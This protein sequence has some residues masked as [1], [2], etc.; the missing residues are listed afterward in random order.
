MKQREFILF[1]ALVSAMAALAIDMLLPAF[2]DIRPDF[3]LDDNSTQLSLTI[4][5]FFVG[6][7]VG[8]LVY[9]PL[10]D[11]WG[12]KRVL[13]L[14]LVLYA[15]AAVVCTLANS[16]T[17]LL[18]GRF[19]WGVGSGGPRTLSQAIVRD[20]Y[21][22]TAMARIMTLIQAAFF[23]GPIIA[24]VLGKG[25]V[26]I[27]SWRWVTAF[28]VIT[29]AAVLLWSVRL[30]ETLPPER[31]RNLEPR[32]IIAGF[33]AVAS[34]RTTVAYGLS[35][36]FGFGAFYSFLASSELIFSSVFERESL[37]VWFFVLI[38]VLFS[39]V[40]IGINRVLKHHEARPV[41]LV[42]G[43]VYASLS[44]VMLIVIA[45]SDGL[46]NFW[47]WVVLFCLT[48][49]GQISFFPVANSLA[50]EPMGQL[51]GTATAALGSVTA[52]MGAVL[53]NQIDRRIDD[54]IWAVGI[55]YA[56]YATIAFGFQLVAV[57][58]VSAT[59]DPSNPD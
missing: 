50:L 27:G 19:L 33:R 39:F 8:F 41:A 40:A 46:P 22:G 37:F 36:T 4:S 38:S 58:S 6:S 26:E 21:S 32:S 9:G 59:N 29:A 5:L 43:G 1:M 47:V 13:S 16:L 52:L 3:G 12:R 10:S 44:I 20:R 28:G 53:G 42:A 2:S 45:A 23:M 57:R 14:S 55:G 48:N 54:T 56:V 30:E 51:A 24:P 7:A 17:V 11:A 34:N 35:V 18:I 15:L 49:A 31:R 25:L